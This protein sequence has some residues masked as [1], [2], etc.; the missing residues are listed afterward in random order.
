MQNARK[1]K[2]GFYYLTVI[3]ATLI[4]LTEL[5]QANPLFSDNTTDGQ[6]NTWS[7]GLVSQQNNGTVT[8]LLPN[9]AHNVGVSCVINN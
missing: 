7:C 8:A 5:L 4:L 3:L 6:P 1:N 9:V 2:R